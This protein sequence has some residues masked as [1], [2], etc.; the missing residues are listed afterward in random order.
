MLCVFESYENDSALAVASFDNACIFHFLIIAM[1]M[2][3]VWKVFA[4]QV[5]H[6]FPVTALFQNKLN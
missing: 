6:V 5:P 1:I 3:C 2:Q 4:E